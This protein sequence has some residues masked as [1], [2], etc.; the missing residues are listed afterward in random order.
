VVDLSG[1]SLTVSVNDPVVCA[2]FLLV[3]WM[4]AFLHLLD[5]DLYELF[6]LSLLSLCGGECT[7]VLMLDI[8]TL[9]NGL[10]RLID[11]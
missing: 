7:G 4:Y 9:W 10:I 11:G 8:Y 3:R 1:F 6:C 5:V 2:S